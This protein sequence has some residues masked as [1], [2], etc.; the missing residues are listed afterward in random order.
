MN[1]NEIAEIYRRALPTGELV[2]FSLSPFDRLG[3]ANQSATFFPPDGRTRG[4]TGYGISDGAALVSALGETTEEYAA[5]RGVTQMPVIEGTLAQL[6]RERGENGVCDPRRLGINAG[7]D[8]SPAT[9]RRWIQVSRWPAGEAVLVPLEYVATY[10][11]DLGGGDYAPLVVPI[12][13]G[14]GAGLSREAAIAHGLLE[15]LQRDGNGLQIRALASLVALDQ[16]TIS[17]PI[18]RELLDRFD[19]QGVDVEIKVAST[20]WGFVNLYVVGIDREASPISALLSAA[21]GEASH[22]VAVVALRKALLEWAAARARLAFMHGPLE[23]V[24]R[25]TPEGYLAQMR[26]D[27]SPHSHE[28]R[29]LDAMTVW[30]QQ[31]LEQAR[32]KLENRVLRVEKRIAFS[33]LPSASASLENDKMALCHDVVRRLEEAGLEVLVADF[34]DLAAQNGGVFAVKVLVAGLEVETLSYGRLGVRNVRRLLEREDVALVARGECPPQGR[35]IQLTPAAEIALDG[36]L[37]LDWRAV[38]E[39]VGPLYA[40]YREPGRHAVPF[41][42][43]MENNHLPLNIG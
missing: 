1:L 20:E 22:P 12:T 28:K 25:L 35:R 24:E 17:D 16:S 43:E 10:G 33:D 42:L 13:N 40:L 23:A 11:G 2:H 26:A 7:T 30:S 38:E 15:L 32:E 9:P 39:L 29:A 37:W 19:A 5:S 14:L 6:Q 4:G 8:F 31:S 27:F 3:V 41:S 36:P 34:S 18:A 21:G